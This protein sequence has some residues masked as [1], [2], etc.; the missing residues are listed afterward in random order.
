MEN[1]RVR[2]CGIMMEHGTND[3]GFWEGFNLSEEDEN[4]IYNILAKYDTEGYSVR[5][6]RKEVLEDI[7]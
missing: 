5:G 2:I 4:M 3:F 7:M 1:D 6:T